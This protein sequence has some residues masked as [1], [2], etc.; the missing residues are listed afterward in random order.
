MILLGSGCMSPQQ[1]QNLGMRFSV[2]GGMWTVGSKMYKRKDCPTDHPK[3]EQPPGIWKTIWPGLTPF[4]FRLTIHQQQTAFISCRGG[5]CIQQ[6]LHQHADGSAVVMVMRPFG[7]GSA[8]FISHM[9]SL[10]SL[11]QMSLRKSF[12]WRVIKA[13]KCCW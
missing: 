4:K 10:C 5:L 11:L 1:S 8:T 9:I 13:P 3:S 6:A 12:L 2:N 7:Q